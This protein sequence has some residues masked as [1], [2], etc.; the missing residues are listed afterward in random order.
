MYS[1]D[2]NLLQGWT[3]FNKWDVVGIILKIKYDIKKEV[4]EFKE[5]CTLASAWKWPGDFG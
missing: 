3:N 5:N 2:L 4:H 1:G